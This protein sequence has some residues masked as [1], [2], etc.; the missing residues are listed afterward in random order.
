MADEKLM[1]DV[2]KYVDEVWEDVVADIDDLIQV[3]S[4]EDRDH[5]AEGM[6]FGPAPREALD[7]ALAMAERLGLKTTNCD[8]WIGFGDIEGK[9]GQIATIAHTDIV[10]VG[11]GW[12]FDPLKLTR[13]DGFLIGRGVMDDKGP[14]VL[15][16]YAAHYLKRLSDASGEPLPHTLRCIVG[17]NEETGMA[18]VDYYL[19]HY[20]EPDFLFTPDADFPLI[21]GEK[22]R[23]QAAFTSADLTGGR[24]AELDG[25]TVANAVCGLA[26]AL[27]SADADALP[28]A[29]AIDVEA[30]GEGMVRLT[31]HGKGG[32]ASM[33]AGTVNA[34]GLLVDYLLDNGVCSDAER[35]YL[36]LERKIMGST[37]GST[38]GIAATDKVFDPLTC[39]GGTVRTKDGR[40]TQTIDS[41]Y[42]S[43]ITSDAIEKAL[44]EVAEAH[45]ATLEIQSAT[46]PFL[47]DPDS[48]E[49]KT[50]V[51]TY[52]EL[53]GSD[54]HAFTIGGGTY[55]RHFRRA[56]AFGPNDPSFEFP[57]WVGPEHGPDEGIAESQ[58]KLALK[59][60]IVGLVRLMG[61][62]E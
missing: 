35:D 24:I 26:T 36:E 7:R 51:A 31:A 37:D 9:A 56:A 34:I 6:P 38:L 43:S 28:A 16:L 10:P 57:D 32:H 21:C 54:G 48:P 29:D 4:V 12:H 42:P 17:C 59:I 45:G 58:L 46:D 18:D 11:L 15:S 62:A 14:F 60:Y 33:P 13:K 39:I 23:V 3:E 40:I 5:A 8:G 20:D 27:V 52:N 47:T 22:G 30:A 25:G 19:A 61:L 44:R 1:S 50:L 49:V 55:A 2:E 41:R 53:T